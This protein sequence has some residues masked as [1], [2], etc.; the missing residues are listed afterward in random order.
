[1]KGGGLHIV[2][3]LRAEV[4]EDVGELDKRILTKERKAVWHEM[5][6]TDRYKTEVI[7][8]L[9]IAFLVANILSIAHIPNVVPPSMA[10]LVTICVECLYALPQVQFTIL[11]IFPLAFL[12]LLLILA[13]GTMLLAADTVSE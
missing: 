9:A 1:M 11:G 6:R 13:F 2:T 3:S 12:S 8:R 7:V 10:L 4:E 5:L